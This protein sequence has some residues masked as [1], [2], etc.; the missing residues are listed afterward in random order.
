VSEQAASSEQSTDFSEVDLSQDATPAPHSELST[1][2]EDAL[3]SVVNVKV[4]AFQSGGLEGRGE[5]S[6]VVIDPEGIILTNNHVIAGAVEVRVLFNDDHEPMDGRV[7]GADPGRDLAV[8]KV[9]ATDLHAIPIGHSDNLK[10]GD[11]VVAIGF[12]LG[13][14]GPTVTKGIVS[15][16]GRTISAQSSDGAVERLVGMLQTD[17]A[18][19]PGNSGGALIDTNGGLV[20]I[21]TAVAGSAEN[22]GFAIAIDGAMPV[23]R[24]FLSKPAERQ[25]WLGI[26]MQTLTQVLDEQLGYPS[27]LR[28]VLIVQVIPGSPA[29]GASIEDGTVVTSIDG[30]EVTTD[31]QL[32]DFLSQKSP[33]DQVTLDLYTPSG[34]SKTVTVELDVRPFTFAKP[35]PSPSS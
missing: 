24:E 28:G 29:E 15:G 3:P 14:G 2:V 35:S 13:L 11:D 26:S 17:A 25:S 9:D 20:G 31:Q 34:D 5:G 33:G 4:H 30:T 27:D 21:N 16:N 6:G 23:V 7:I 32:A 22:V 10:L 12:P 1:I 19:N 18:I 8:I